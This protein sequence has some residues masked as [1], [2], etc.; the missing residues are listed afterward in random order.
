M[1]VWLLNTTQNKFITLNK[2]KKAGYHIACVAMTSFFLSLCTFARHQLSDSLITSDFPPE[3][4][5][6]GF[7]TTIIEKIQHGVS[8]K[9]ALTGPLVRLDYVTLE[10]HVSQLS[11]ND[12]LLY[13]ALSLNLVHNYINDAGTRDKFLSALSIGESDVQP[14]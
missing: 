8:L 9:D 12:K 3:Q 2:H 5:L 11:A 7:T 1:L 13:Q 10:Q 6:L 4:L 14:E